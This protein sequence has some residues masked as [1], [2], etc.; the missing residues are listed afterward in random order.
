MS[1]QH[2][3][4]GRDNI[5][6]TSF[7]QLI[8]SS[9]TTFTSQ[10]HPILAPCLKCLQGGWIEDRHPLEGAQPGHLGQLRGRS[11]WLP[12]V[13]FF[14]DTWDIEKFR[15]H[16]FL[17]NIFSTENTYNPKFTIVVSCCR[18]FF[19]ATPNDNPHSTADSDSPN[20]STVHSLRR[21]PQ[22]RRYAGCALQVQS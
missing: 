11:G 10:P 1:L 6:K 13:F 19:A 20:F 12:M 3:S 2:K 15:K 22:Q 18:V 8:N 17:N 5:F 9:A 4:Y 14:E 16:F 21:P 7:N